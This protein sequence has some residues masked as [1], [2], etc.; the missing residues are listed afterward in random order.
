MTWQR[1]VRKLGLGDA[2]EVNQG[3]LD[4]ISLSRKDCPL[5]V[6]YQREIGVS[7][8][9]KSLYELVRQ[10]HGRGGS[11]GSRRKKREVA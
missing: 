6:L 2:V 3:I 7:E 8:S 1:M 5:N 9:R 11:L 4:A 10:K